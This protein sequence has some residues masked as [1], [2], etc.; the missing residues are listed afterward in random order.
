MKRLFRTTNSWLTATCP[1]F[2]SLMRSDKLWARTYAGVRYYDVGNVFRGGSLL[3]FLAISYQE[4]MSKR[5]L[6][7]RQ[8]YASSLTGA[9]ARGT[10]RSRT[11][12]DIIYLVDSFLS[13]SNIYRL[14]HGPVP[15]FSGFSAPE[16]LALDFP[17][18]VFPALIFPALVFPSF[19]IRTLSMI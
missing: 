19:P 18:L 2:N 10:V 13:G 1:L 8:M 16:F 6:Q 14:A 7:C 17:A 15:R 12:H 5:L 3:P 9:R 11:T 4:I